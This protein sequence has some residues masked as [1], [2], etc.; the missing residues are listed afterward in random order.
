MPNENIS[1][2]N[3]IMT[4]KEKPRALELIKIQKCQRLILNVASG[5]IIK[6]VLLKTKIYVI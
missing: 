3:K 6:C 5:L 1:T 4:R 2:I